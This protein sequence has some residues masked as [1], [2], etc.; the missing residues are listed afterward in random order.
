M[1]LL[2]N[3]FSAPVLALGTGLLII[4]VVIIVAIVGLL[5]G[6]FVMYRRQNAP[7]KP[8]EQAKPQNL[9]GDVSQVQGTPGGAGS[10]FGPGPGGGPDPFAGFAGAASAAAPQASATAHDAVAAQATVAPQAA[11]AAPAAPDAPTPP[12]AQSPADM[13]PPPAGTEAG[14]LPD[15]T[16]VP[17]TLRYWD[18]GAWTTHVAQR[19][20][21]G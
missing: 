7:A 4:E 13:A 17:D 5:I 8:Q 14:W 10:P 15:P 18:G 20:A 12:L 9:Y 11:P 2:A 3:H 16:G 21:P 1:G 6:V 19:S